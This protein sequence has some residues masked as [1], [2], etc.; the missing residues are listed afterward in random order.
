M[1][2]I[3]RAIRS[4]P[5]QSVGLL[6]E[7]FSL[8]VLAGVRSPLLTPGILLFCAI[9]LVSKRISWEYLGFVNIRNIPSLLLLGFLIA[10][11]YQALSIFLFVP[12]ITAL[13]G[14]SLDLSEITALRENWANL[15]IALLISWTFAA[16]GEEIAYRSYLYDRIANLLPGRRL[17]SI[18]GVVVCTALFSVGH[19]YQGLSGVLENAVF[20]LMMALVF[21]L[22]KKNLWLP[23]IVHGFV[24]TIGFILIFSGLYP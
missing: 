6:L 5:R 2:G 11:A 7:F 16:F 19:G 17:G 3:F 9:R 10:A 18:I 20:G 1:A 12:L 22:C 13:T 15:A 23:V 8:L 4:D 24:D 14:S 21:T